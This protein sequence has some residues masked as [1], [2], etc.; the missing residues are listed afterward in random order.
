MTT[1][2]AVLGDITTV[3]VDA[4][5]NAANSHLAGGG[6]VDGA[7]HRAGGP[8]ILEEC[9][10]WVAAHGRLP[11]GQAMATTAGRLPAR[12]VI[13][14]VGPIWAE[15][16][17]KTACRLLADCYRNSLDLALSLGCRSVAFPNISTGVYGFP[18][19]LAAR[20]AV[21]AVTEWVREKQG[22]DRIVF[23]CFDEQ[24]FRLYESLLDSSE[25]S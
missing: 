24:N 8:S 18:K 16:D 7:I 14:T 15:H 19:P 23:V 4:V 21:G 3:E 25:D 20:T 22:I 2:T 10:R 5:V 17:Q 9:R 11:T 13:H 6:G 1:I 12:Y